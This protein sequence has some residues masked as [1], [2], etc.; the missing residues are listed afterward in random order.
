MLLSTSSLYCGYTTPNVPAGVSALDNPSEN[1][2]IVKCRTIKESAIVATAELIL[3]YTLIIQ[4]PGLRENMG[5]ASL[6]SNV[7]PALG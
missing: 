7:L 1:T 3:N 5:M 2:V 6:Y 4:L